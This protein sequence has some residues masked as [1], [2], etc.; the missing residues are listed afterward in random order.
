MR[1]NL[2]PSISHA[3]LID[4]LIG[5]GPVNLSF[6]CYISAFI[7]ILFHG[8]AWRRLILA[9][10]TLSRAAARVRVLLGKICKGKMTDAVTLCDV[11]EPQI[12]EAKDYS[13]F[14][15]TI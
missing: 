4:D 10:P 8:L 15:I 2:P 13:D 11:W 5:P 1:N 3:E 6:L 7:Q 12:H 14:T 9:W